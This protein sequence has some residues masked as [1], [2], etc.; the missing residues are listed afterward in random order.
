MADKH[1]SAINRALMDQDS[2]VSNVIGGNKGNRQNRF[3]N[4]QL[5]QVLTVLEI[6]LVE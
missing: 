1:R 4:H 2:S 6:I 5:M 3:L